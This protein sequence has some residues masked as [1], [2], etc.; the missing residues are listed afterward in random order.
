MISISL[1]LFQN[2]FESLDEDDKSRANKTADLEKLLRECLLSRRIQELIG[3]YIVME[4]YFMRESVTKVSGL[5][6]GNK[7]LE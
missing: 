6:D 3:N 5:L 7:W 4:E 1:P 2:D